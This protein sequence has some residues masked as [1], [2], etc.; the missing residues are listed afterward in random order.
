MR[1]HTFGSDAN[2]AIVLIHGMLNPWQL[3]QQA[4]DAFSDEFFIIVPELDAHTEDEPSEF[5]TIEKEAEQSRSGSI[6]VIF[7][8]A[9]YMRYAGF[10]WEAGLLQ[11]LHLFR[12]LQQRIW[13]WTVRLCFLCQSCWSTS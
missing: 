9:V 10:L 1:F 3:W 4:I 8:A 12:G 7:A 11:H 13:C 2:K 6:F 5:E